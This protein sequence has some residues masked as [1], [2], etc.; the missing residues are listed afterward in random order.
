M[1]SMFYSATSFNKD[2]SG[3]TVNNNVTTCTNFDTNA[4]S[5]VLS[6]PNFTSCTI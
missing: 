5:W 1:S 4:T 2:L 6:R 3:W